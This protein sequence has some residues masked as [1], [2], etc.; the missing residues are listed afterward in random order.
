MEQQKPQLLQVKQLLQKILNVSLGTEVFQPKH[1][2]HD[3]SNE[4]FFIDLFLN[5]RCSEQSRQVNVYYYMLKLH[6][7]AYS[8]VKKEKKYSYVI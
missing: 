2:R 7:Q 3:C 8:Y 6:P 1:F 5:E 4:G